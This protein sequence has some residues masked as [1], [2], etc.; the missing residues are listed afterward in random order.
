MYD[1]IYLQS[2][3]TR[4]STTTMV[5]VVVVAASIGDDKPMTDLC[6]IMFDVVFRSHL[7]HHHIFGWLLWP[8][9]PSSVSLSFVILLCAL[10]APLFHF[11]NLCFVFN[12]VSAAKA[13]CVPFGIHLSALKHF[14]FVACGCALYCTTYIHIEW[15]VTWNIETHEPKDKK[16]VCIHDDDNKNIYYLVVQRS[17]KRQNDRTNVKNVCVFV[18]LSDMSE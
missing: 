4:S 17:T 3:D 6:E 5:V 12:L 18:G 1:D 10:C 16:A 9:S 2:G 13:V 8:S 7:L 11:V 15:C 14:H